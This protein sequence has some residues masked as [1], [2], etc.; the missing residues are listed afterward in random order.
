MRLIPNLLINNKDLIKNK[1]FRKYKYLGD[2]VNVAKIYLEKGADELFIVDNSAYISGINFALIEE[3]SSNCFIP[4]T[5][6]GNIKDIDQVKSLVKIGIERVAIG[7]YSKK[8]WNIV[9]V[10]SDYLGKSGVCPIINVGLS[11]FGEKYKI[12]DYKLK[13]NRIRYRFNKVIDDLNENNPGETII[14]DTKNEGTRRGFSLSFIR[15]LIHPKI[16]LIAGG[17]IKNYEECKNLWERGFNAVSCS[18]FLSLVLPHDAVLISYPKIHSDN[19]IK[20]LTKPR[21][22][23]DRYSRYN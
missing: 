3:L 9:K 2:P 8:D 17:G 22:S 16:P 19:L 1:S 10:A 12:F 6:A 13:R 14:F 21:I 11:R 18:A 4:I 23:F 7:I 15:D 5:Y 20:D